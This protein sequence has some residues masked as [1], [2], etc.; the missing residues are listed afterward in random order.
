MTEKIDIY[1]SEKELS[2]TEIASLKKSAFPYSAN[3]LSSQEPA[4]SIALSPL[5]LAVC[6][7]YKKSSNYDQEL[8]CCQYQPELWRKD[9]L[10]LFI[11]PRQSDK[12][13]QE[14]NFSPSGAYWQ[15]QFS[16]YREKVIP[17]EL[18]IRDI[19]IK[20][21]EKADLCTL[22]AKIARNELLSISA[23]SKVNCCSIFGSTPRSYYAC[24]ELNKIDFHVARLWP[25]VNFINL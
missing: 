14:L 4:F 2:F 22:T 20:L 11:L 17:T 18:P 21:D 7:E 13:Y 6:Y 23:G 5:A 10:E 25:T 1:L 24:S 8:N 9:V 12:T 3:P 15:A 19:S 16:D